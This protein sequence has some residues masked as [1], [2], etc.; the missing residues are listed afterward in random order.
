M[1]NTILLALLG[2]GAVALAIALFSPDPDVK[3]RADIDT[4]RRIE[5]GRIRRDAERRKGSKL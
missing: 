2:I 5:R 1:I 4:Q 3:R